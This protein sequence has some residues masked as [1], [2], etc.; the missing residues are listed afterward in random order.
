MD[1]EERVRERKRVG[2]RDDPLWRRLSYMTIEPPGAAPTF[3][4]RLAREQGWAPAFAEKVVGEYRRFLYLAGKSS[5]PVTPPPAVDR[6]WHLHLTYSQHYWS[7]LCANVL[8]REL[9]HVPSHGGPGD[10]ARMRAQYRET[11]MLY[12]LSF[13]TRPPQSIWPSAHAPLSEEGPFHIPAGPIVA[14]TSALF[15][16][17]ACLLTAGPPS[18]DVPLLRMGVF[19]TAIAAFI[20]SIWWIAG[21]RFRA[22][23]G[24][25]VD[26]ASDGSGACGGGGC[27]GCG[28]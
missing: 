6:A 24:C 2:Y 16:A 9:H 20:I 5:I 21:A 7:E 14:A 27:G 23:I 3:A 26:F 13:G 15:V 12:E 28:G 19:M 11:L 17:G 8:R 18:P 1:A 4:Q 22:E 25:G 10:L